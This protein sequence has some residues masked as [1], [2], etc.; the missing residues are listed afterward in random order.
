MAL[1][2]VKLLAKY[3]SSVDLDSECEG[4]LATLTDWLADPACS[5]NPTVLLMAATIYARE[6][7]FNEALKCA[8]VGT[9]LE[10]MAM[11]VQMFLKLDRVD[12]AE[13]QLKAMSAVDDDSTL[14]Q[15]AT[16]WVNIALGGNKVQEA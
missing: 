4:I 9:T 6:G 3:C 12:F 16:A 15:L 14:T 8:H 13:K 7:N 5:N 2:A 11:S 1:Q 10:L